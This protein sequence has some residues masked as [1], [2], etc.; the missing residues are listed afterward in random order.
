MEIV[1]KKYVERPSTYE[2]GEKIFN[3]IYPEIANNERVEV[4]F[5]GIESVPSAFINAAFIRLLEKVTFE[6]IKKY[7]QIV[8]STHHINTLIQNRFAFAV[9]KSELA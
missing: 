2:D 4:S 6:D 1:I 5:A 9:K 3:L 7:L 8:N